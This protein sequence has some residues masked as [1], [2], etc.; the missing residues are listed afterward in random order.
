[1]IDIVLA[2]LHLR[3][4]RPIED[5]RFIWDSSKTLGQEGHLVSGYP[6]LFD[7]FPNDLLV[8]AVGVDIG[9]IPG[10]EAYC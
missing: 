2:L 7:R 10:R 9:N 3:L 8:Y 6:E 5:T 4:K 1:M